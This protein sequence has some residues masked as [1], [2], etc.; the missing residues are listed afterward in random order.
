VSAVPALLALLDGPPDVAVVAAGAL[1]HIG[2]RRA[3]ETLVGQLDHPHA[4]LRQVAVASLNSIGHPDMAGRLPAMLADASP[5]VR[6]SAARI[7]GYFGDRALLEPMLTVC[8]DPDESVR[9]AAVEQ[10][11]R[12]EDPRA[13][14]AVATALA[15]DTPGVRAAAVR[16]LAHASEEDAQP[17]LAKACTDA[18]PWVR[19]HAARS[20]G[21]FS[22]PRA[23]DALVA[24][25]IHDAMPPV[26]IAAVEALAALGDADALAALCPL[27]DDPDP[28]VAAPALVALGGARDHGTLDAL[29][30]ALVHED[31]VRRLAAMRA[32]ARRADPASLKDIVA[33]AHQSTDP[34]EREQ[35]MDALAAL[36]DERAVAAL[37]DLGREPRRCSL[38]VDV[39]GRLPKDRV[40]WLRP[41]LHHEDVAVRFAVIEALGRM[42]HRE[43]SSLLAEALEDPAPAV[44]A[45]AAHAL[46][47][48]DLRATTG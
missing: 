7:A 11:P 8:A 36:D 25:A 24:L 43:A 16:A 2:D 23:R 15:H 41:S 48:L 40:R 31:R 6:E 5:R 42:R 38:V 34:E 22:N 9:R 21:H 3:F 14:A 46:A 47:R 37:A 19:Y 44:T 29:R 28:A 18:D 1:G 27:A 30:S 26:R 20:L 39:L 33:A 35:A 45:A 17:G 10:L 13:L 4:A 12:F 32:L